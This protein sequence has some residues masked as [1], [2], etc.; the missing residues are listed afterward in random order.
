MPPTNYPISFTV[1]PNLPA[2]PSDLIVNSFTWSHVALSW[3]DDST[4]ASDYEIQRATSPNGPFTTI[5]TVSGS[6]T[7]FTDTNATSQTTFYYRLVADNS[8]G[9]SLPSADAAVATSLAPV[10]MWR[11]LHFNTTANTGI[12]AD[13][14]D[15]DHDGLV[16]LVEYA[17]VLDPNSASAYPIS[18]NVFTNHVNLIFKRPHPAPLDIDYIFE[19]SSDLAS[20]D[21]SSAPGAT[22]Q[23]TVNNN[24][25]TETV[26]LTDGAPISPNTAHYLRIRIARQ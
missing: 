21:W 5:A 22:T 10:D 7:N 11:Q 1:S 16:N 13:N 17:F 2:A 19:T 23:T 6:A 25:G 8:F 14:A 18:F 3:I 9:N 20:G 26:T 15:P 24:D 4:N 12:A